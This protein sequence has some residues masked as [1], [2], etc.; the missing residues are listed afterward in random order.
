MAHLGIIDGFIAQHGTKEKH[1]NRFRVEL[2]L[3]GKLKGEF[4]EGIDHLNPKQKLRNVLSQFEGN[5]LDDIV[6]RATNENI[7]SYLFFTLKDFPINSLK[8]VEEG[9]QYVTLFPEDINFEDYPAKIHFRK[10]QSL[11]M[12]EKPSLAKREL[13]D[14]ISLKKDFAEAYNLRGR[15]HKYLRDHTSALSDYFKAIRINPNFGEAYRNIGNAH[16]YLNNDSLMI[17]AFTK[18]IELMP[19]SALAYAN[20]GFAYQKLSVFDLALNDQDKAIKLDP[21]YEE[22]Y[23]DRAQSYEELSRPSLAKKDLEMAKELRDTGRD[24]YFGITMYC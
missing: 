10:A 17:P 4:V 6:G 15:C 3:E 20:R 19:T 24:T 9:E 14:A 22:A 13:N 5:Y 18:A 23:R 11:L 2:T 8:V 21:N 1:T 7:A 12:R 16:Y